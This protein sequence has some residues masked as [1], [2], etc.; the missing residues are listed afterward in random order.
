MKNKKLLFMVVAI[1]VV[2]TILSSVAVEAAITDDIRDSLS[3]IRSKVGG[4]GR[5]FLPVIV[6][7]IILGLVFY[8]LATTI[9]GKWFG[10][11]SKQGKAVLVIVIIIA[12]IYFAIQIGEKTSGE[13]FKNKFIWGTPVFKDGVEYLFGEEKADGTAGILTPKRLFIFI[14]LSLLI[15][16][17]FIAVLNVGKGKHKIDAALAIII[18]MDA[19]HSGVIGKNGVITLGQFIATYLL[20]RQFKSERGGQTRDWGALVWA[21]ALVSIISSIGFPD[22]GFFIFRLFNISSPGGLIKTIIFWFALGLAIPLLGFGAIKGA[23]KSRILTDGVS[24]LFSGGLANWV[25]SSKNVLARFLRRIRQWKEGE[26]EEEIPFEFRRRKIEFATLMNYLLRIQIYEIKK[27]KVAELEVEINKIKDDTYK[28]VRAANRLK[29]DIYEYKQGMTVYQDPET[30]EWKTKIRIM[31]FST[32]DGALHVHPLPGRD[33]PLGG[34]KY[35]EEYGTS[36]EYNIEYVYTK[37]KELGEIGFGNHRYLMFTVVNHLKKVLENTNNL[38]NLNEKELELKVSY[39]N[40]TVGPYIGTVDNFFNIVIN[41]KEPP[42]YTMYYKKNH[43][44][45]KHYGWT[46]KRESYRMQVQDQNNSSR[47]GTYMHAYHYCRAWAM[48]MLIPAKRVEDKETGD[49]SVVPDIDRMPDDLTKLARY[50]AIV[51]VQDEYG[52]FGS[53]HTLYEVDERGIFMDDFNQIRAKNE[54]PDFLSDGEEMKKLEDV[55]KLDDGLYYRQVLPEEMFEHASPQFIMSNLNKYWL[56]FTRDFRTG[57]YHPCSRSVYDYIQCHKG[58]KVKGR[59]GREKVIG[60]DF[61]YSS[62]QRLKKVS[63]DN[64]AFDR[65]ALKDPGKFIHRGLRWHN[66]TEEVDLNT[67]PKNYAPAI[68]TQ[69]LT[70]YL[71]SR[72]KYKVADVKSRQKYLKD[73]VFDSLREDTIFEFGGKGEE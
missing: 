23:Q 2:L 46:Q 37:P 18:S 21:F 26:P 69:G 70:K 9:G 19:A 44:N 10:A 51:G 39:W 6:N 63:E 41:E 56:Y 73:W 61:G 66:I 48:P 38:L 31:E 43:A 58:Q 62:L 28:N 71:Q 14:G 8:L 34:K 36:K 5:D 25:L 55:S 72:I 22:K 53:T 16:W 54:R 42:F 49:V 60:R 7:A 20:Y 67:P 17:L 12:S 13:L 45:L 59:L 24:Y 64:P 32:D 30:T 1:L 47:G 40:K 57:K 27:N 65:E 50:K 33:Y 4:R 29:S 3:N 52:T 68:S 35:T 11:G 15:S